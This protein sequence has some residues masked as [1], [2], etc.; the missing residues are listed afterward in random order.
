MIGLG[1]QPDLD[2]VEWILDVL[3]NYACYLDESCQTFPVQ[4]SV[5]LS[6][7]VAAY[8]SVGNVLN[9]VYGCH[10]SLSR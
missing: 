3:P 6:A 7:G 8:R 10:P 5:C 2:R 1:L 4:Q 9:R